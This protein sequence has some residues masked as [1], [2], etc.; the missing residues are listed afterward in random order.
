M[1]KTLMAGVIASLFAFAGSAS[2]APLILDLN[3]TASGGQITATALDWSQTSFV[4]VNGNQA[5]TNFI[6]NAANAGNPLWV[7]LPTTFDIYTHAKLTGYTDGLGTAKSLPAVAGE[8]TIVAKFTETVTSATALA[9][10]GIATF[11][12]TGAGWIEMYYSSTANSAALTGS[13]YN[14]GT[15]IMRGEGVGAATGTF[16]NLGGSV[17]LDGFNDG[18]APINDYTGQLSVNGTGSQQS[19]TFGSGGFAV[20]TN[21]LKTE[22]ADFSIL[23]ENISTGLPYSTVDPSDCFNTSMSGVSNAAITAGTATGNLSTCNI[24]HVTGKYSDQNAADPGYLPVVGDTNGTVFSPL[25]PTNPDFVAQTDF[26]SAV[27]GTVPEPG[28]LALLGLALAGMGFASRRR[29]A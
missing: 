11:A 13:G 18:V 28:S 19:I 2:A 4:A 22:V 16:L 5:I 17:P 7:T 29:R 23:F 9:V 1:R 8:I 24:T 6:L 20:D 25:S 10:G 12:T 3:G 15:L 21:F 27:S 14:D 26:N